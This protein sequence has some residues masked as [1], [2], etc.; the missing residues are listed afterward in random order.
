MFIA[1]YFFIMNV[2]LPQIGGYF[3]AIL[4]PIMVIVIT[5]A[6]IVMLFGAVG[7]KISSNSGSTVVSGAFRAIG[8]IGTNLIRLIGRI[9]RYILTLIPRVFNGCKKTF[10]QAGLNDLLCNVFSVIITIVFIAIII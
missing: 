6:G 5:F 10:N 7:M 1:L 2:V 9:I 8:Y 4:E 3:Q